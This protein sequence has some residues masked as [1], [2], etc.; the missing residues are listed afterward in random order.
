MRAALAAVL[1]LAPFIALA[2]SAPIRPK[3]WNIPKMS[4]VVEAPGRTYV[5]GLPVSIRAIRSAEKPEALA[6]DLFHQF[7]KAG[8]FIPPAHHVPALLPDAIQVTGLD[9]DTYVVYTAFVQAGPGGTSTV[10]LTET[11]I[12]E[13][14]PRASE[15]KFAPMMPEARGLITSRTEGLDWMQYRVGADASQVRAF[16]K[17]ALGRAK[18]EPRDEDVYR[19]GSEELVLTVKREGNETSV[20]LMKRP[21]IDTMNLGAPLTAP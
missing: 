17:D 9:P 19:R 1:L 20:G 14:R 8:L 7:T 6:R 13:R 12:A 21:A 3:V 10:I 5:D 18:Y 2:Q 4:D 11:S 16:Y 15:A